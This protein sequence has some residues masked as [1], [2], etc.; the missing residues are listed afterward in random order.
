LVGQFTIGVPLE[1]EQC[2]RGRG[3]TFKAKVRNCVFDSFTSQEA[4]GYSYRS[5]RGK[6]RHTQIL[7]QQDSNYSPQG[8]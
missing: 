7:S 5:G 6:R 2:F 1:E 4:L 8:H 3:K